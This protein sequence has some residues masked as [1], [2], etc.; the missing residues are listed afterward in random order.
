M[1]LLSFVSCTR[2]ITVM[3]SWCVPWMIILC[4]W[5]LRLGKSW[6]DDSGRHKRGGGNNSKPRYSQVHCGGQSWN[7]L[8]S[9]V[10][11]K[12]CVCR[13]TRHWSWLRQ[14]RSYTCASVIER[15]QFCSMRPVCD[16]GMKGTKRLMISRCSLKPT[17]KEI[18]RSA[19]RCCKPYILNVSEHK[20]IAFPRFYSFF[21]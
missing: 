17:V 15:Y 10:E 20:F 12:M 14:Y 18:H 4:N 21:G 5:S 3:G 13:V 11:G 2:W 19:Q 16:I 6:W 7:T 9:H 1:P 8:R